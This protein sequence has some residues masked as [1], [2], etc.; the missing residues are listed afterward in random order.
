MN[1]VTRKYRLMLVHE[2][3]T[4]TDWYVRVDGEQYGPY[5]SE[6]LKMYASEG[7]VTRDSE[8][9]RG[10]DGRWV[11]ASQVKG[12]FA[13]VVDSAPPPPPPRPSSGAVSQAP[14]SAVSTEKSNDEVTLYS[15]SPSMFRNS[16]VMFVV[17]ILLSLVVIG[18]IMLLVWYLRCYGTR[19][20]ITNK[21]TKLRTG[22]LS[23][24]INEVY[25]RD[26]RNVRLS[27]T[28]LQRIFDVGSLEISSA[29]QADVEIAVSGMPSPEK[30]K[31]IIDEHRG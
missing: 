22:I 17:C 6:Q 11:I 7:H 15:A 21:R 31:A 8:V 4:M 1:A 24:Q 5:T 27:Q 16:P 23:K 3:Q 10:T 30:M 12:M 25:H 26:V 2:K 20:T 29:G 13:D 14:T 28:F 19:L 18:L 9:R